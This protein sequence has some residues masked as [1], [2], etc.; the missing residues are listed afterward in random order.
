MI[1]NLE[2]ES[3][4]LSD[5]NF[6]EIPGMNCGKMFKLTEVI[7]QYMGNSL[8]INGTSTG[9]VSNSG[10]YS[11]AYMNMMNLLYENES[12][13]SSI[14]GFTSQFNNMRTKRIALSVI[15]E[16]MYTEKI[17]QL[18]D[19]RANDFIKENMTHIGNVGS[20][21]SFSQTKLEFYRSASCQLQVQMTTEMPS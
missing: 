19:S 10:F 4:V 15:N 1:D 7:T 8:L 12:R 3:F 11:N 2:R 5:R 9:G 16:N 13:K 18:G 14:G 20:S 17:V 6:S 21:S